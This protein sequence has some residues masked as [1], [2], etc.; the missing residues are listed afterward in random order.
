[1][2]NK[3]VKEI[4]EI[5][6]Q[7]WQGKSPLFASSLTLDL[8]GLKQ[9]YDVRPF[10]MQLNESDYDF[11]T[12]LWRSEGISWLIDEAELTVASNMDNIQP[13]KLRLI[14]DNNQY[15]A[16]TRRAIRYHRSSA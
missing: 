10:V 7:E 16:L 1:F 12:R 5:L 3:S 9:T 6:F 11:L 15:Q 8:S 4:S 2:M 14:D 13:Q